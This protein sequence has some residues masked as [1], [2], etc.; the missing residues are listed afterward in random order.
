M[1][2]QININ[3]DKYYK[4]IAHNVKKQPCCKVIP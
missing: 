2:V 3:W 1:Y 4:S